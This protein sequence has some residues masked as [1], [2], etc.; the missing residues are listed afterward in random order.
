MAS[1]QRRRW[2]ARLPALV[3]T[4]GWMLAA[5]PVH[6]QAQAQTQTPGAPTPRVLLAGRMGDRALLMIDG[7]PQVLGLGQSHQGVKLL[8]WQDDAAVVETGGRSALLRVGG[9]PAQLAPGAP[10][11]S[12]R[13]IVITAGP[14]GH[15]VA[16]G[17][18]NGKAVQF[19]VDTGATRVAMSQGD[20]QRLGLDLRNAQRGMTLTANGPVPVQQLTL[21][22]VR[23]GEVEINNVEAVVLPA[24]MPHVLLGNSFLARFQMRRENDVMRLTPR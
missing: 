2:L 13:E 17:A 18:I 24:A 16:A 22:R 6:S 8:R 15:F 3:G 11:T 5:G 19:M 1:P 9:S 10:D 14:G 12:P 4:A 20:A 21:S 7:Q 23:V